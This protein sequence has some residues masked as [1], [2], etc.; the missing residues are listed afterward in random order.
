MRKILLI[1]ILC[2]FLIS[3]PVLSSLKITVNEGESPSF[4]DLPSYFDLRDYNGENY[5]S[6]VKHQTSGTCWC[7][8]V[9]AA[10]EGNLLITGNW[11]STGGIGDPNLAEYHLDWWNGFNSFN[12]DDDPSGEGLEVHNGGD[13]LVASAYITRG[14]GA[15]FSEDA[16]NGDEYDDNWFYSVPD[17]FDPSYQIF[18]PKDIEWYVAE[19]DLSNIDLIKTKIM[20][21]GVIGTCMCYDSSFID[22]YVHY[23]PPSSGMDP[24]HAVAIVGW[25]D[26]KVTQGPQPGAWLCKNSW[27]SGWGLNGYFWISYYDKHCCQQPQMGA[28]SFQDV[29]LLEYNNIYYHDYHGWRDTMQDCSEAFNAFIAEAN[30]TLESVSFF[31]ATDNVNYIVK[32]YDNFESGELINELTTKS[33]SIEFTGFH[34]IKLDESVYL[35]EDDEFYIYL[36]LSD[37]GQPYD[38]TSD[39]PVLLGGDTKTIV[40]SSASEGESFYKSGSEWIDL[41]LYDDPPWSE[42]ANFCIKGL[43]KRPSLSIVLPEGLPEFILPSEVTKIK[44]EVIENYDNLVEGSAMLHY[45]FDDGDF[46]SDELTSLGGNLYEAE[47]PAADY[48]DF[49]QFYFS[50]EGETTGIIYNPTDAPENYYKINLSLPD[51]SIHTIEDG[52]GISFSIENVGNVNTS[53]VI[54]NVTIQGGLFIF[55]KEMSAEIGSMS[56]GESQD[57]S[58]SLFGLGVGILSELPEIKIIVKSDHSEEIVRTKEAIIIGNK[59]IFQ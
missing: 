24:N 7:H 31:T 32:I 57:I 48:G 3:T 47:L 2:T 38:R 49:P 14:E 20:D 17:R 16:N 28:V 12:N 55:P 4:K 19:S 54:W 36:Q 13:Y 51:L 15:V 40:E 6:S 41:Q 29:E 58:I 8:G 25:D 37:G 33:G 52:N 43:T 53:N 10:I 44:V 5:V 26:D 39:V 9:M 27:G 59:V 35:T 30:E 23:Q 45:R 42:T 11:E 1:A 50:A 56:I 22:D 34:T 18:Y 21:E 46:N